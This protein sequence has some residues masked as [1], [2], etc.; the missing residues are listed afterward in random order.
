METLEY[1]SRSRMWDLSARTKALLKEAKQIKQSEAYT[2]HTRRKSGLTSPGGWHVY[3]QSP[4]RLNAEIASVSARIIE[5][6][7]SV[8]RQIK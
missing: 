6:G 7:G 2:L 5:T 1:I 4:S 3:V 8:D